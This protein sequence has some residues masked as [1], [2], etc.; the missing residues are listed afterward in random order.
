MI[1]VLAFS[2]VCV[3]SALLVKNIRREYGFFISL[4][5]AVIIFTAS[6]GGLKEI[7][8]TVNELGSQENSINSAVKL[9]IKL[10]GVALIS[11]FICNMCDDAGEKMLS[12]QTLLYSRIVMTVMLLPLISSLCNIVF[13]LINR[14]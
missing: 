11:E 3:L 8:E 6:L 9:L 4:A 5:G 13:G 14:I 12:A 1:K 2:A 7:F 10:F